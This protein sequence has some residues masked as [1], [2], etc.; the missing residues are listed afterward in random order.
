M[1]SGISTSAMGSSEKGSANT[2]RGANEPKEAVNKATFNDLVLSPISD[3]YLIPATLIM[4][5]QS[6]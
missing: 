6:L 1:A 2:S 4:S 3:T 5:L